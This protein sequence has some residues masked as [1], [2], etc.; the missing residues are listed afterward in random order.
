[1]KT[2]IKTSVFL[3]VL[4]LTGFAKNLQAQKFVHPGVPFTADDLNKLKADLN[5]EPWK[6]AYAALAAD[7]H[8]SLDYQ[9]QGPFALV[10]RSP[11]INRNQWINDM[12]AV[13]NLTFMWVFT[14]NAA[15]A[16]KATDI[17][18]TWAI[19]NTTWKGD[20]AILDIGDWVQYYATAA[21]ILKSMYS[22]WT[23]ANTS[24]VGN[25]FS[26]VLWPTLD[27]PNPVRGANQGADAIKAAVGIAAYLD[28]SKKFNQAL[29]SLRNDPAGGIA[30]S[31]SNGQL[32]DYGRDGGHSAGQLWNLAWA[33]EVAWKQGIDVYADMDNRL[34]AAGEL[35]AHYNID[36]TGIKFIPFGNPYD[37]YTKWGWKGGEHREPRALNVLINAYANRK[38]MA[39]PYMLQLRNMVNETRESFLY[40]KTADISKASVKAPMV[41]PAATALNKLEQ[42]DIGNTGLA[43]SLNY[44]GGAWT[45]KGAGKFTIPASD[46]VMDAFHFAYKPI[47]GNALM[48]VKVA[49]VENNQEGAWVGL[50]LRE[51]LTENSKFT[52]IFLQPSIGIKTTWR[53]AIAF[54]KT[55]LSWAIKTQTPRNYEFHDRVKAPYWLKIERLGNRVSMY[56]S[57]D[58]VNW[59]CLESVEIAMP[60]M[61]YLGLCVSSDGPG[62]LNTAMFNNVAVSK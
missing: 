53:D 23:T 42:C 21:D 61:A 46:T 2:K 47:K 22:G 12:Q 13:H 18:N 16:Q 15:Y 7:T 48:I 54:C 1:M 62:S 10:S 4:F 58:A 60:N 29:A 5:T 52:G 34:L 50:M 36:T 26:N 24:N 27:V 31:L 41:H 25:Y 6:S 33:A 44:K 59:T 32:G 51:S 14:N 57:P 38:G 43:G 3:F 8:S 28:D 35:Y 17:L 49:S 37:Y 55:D 9:M 19:T 56:H 20:E 40:R 39:T 30:N 11:H 45:I